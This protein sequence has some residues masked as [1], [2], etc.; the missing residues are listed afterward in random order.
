MLIG[1]LCLLQRG[2]VVHAQHVGQQLC[3]ALLL[4]LYRDFQY[5]G[6]GIVAAKEHIGIDLDALGAGRDR[7]FGHVAVV[8]GAAFGL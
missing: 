8:N 7:K 2:I 4:L 6:V 1:H 3:D 5:L